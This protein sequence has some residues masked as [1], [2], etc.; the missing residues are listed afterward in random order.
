MAVAAASARMDAAVG[1]AI[2]L[3]PDALELG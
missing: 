1:L 3:L 2:G